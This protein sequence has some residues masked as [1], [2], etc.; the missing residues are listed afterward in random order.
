MKNKVI[1]LFVPGRLCIM[2]EH[3]DWTGKYRNINNKINKGYAIVTGIEEVYL[4]IDEDDQKE[5][6]NLFSNK[7]SNDITNKLSKEL[8]DYDSKIQKIGKKEN[9]EYQLTSVLDEI[10][11]NNGMIAFIPDGN[12]LDVGNVESYKNTFIEKSIC[13]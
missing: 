6:D 13:N 8:L 4:I 5:Y 3:S 2:G 12:M 9:G 7:L 11:R 10:R 1:N